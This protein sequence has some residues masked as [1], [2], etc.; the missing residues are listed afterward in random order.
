[1]VSN[2]PTAP[3]VA[4]PSK[5]RRGELKR[6][7]ARGKAAAVPAAGGASA[8]ERADK[9]IQKWRTG[10]ARLPIE[11]AVT[12]DPALDEAFRLIG[13]TAAWKILQ[14]AALES[15]AIMAE[16]RSYWNPDD[17]VEVR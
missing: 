7:Y 10:M 9:H 14:E 1:M 8:A 6:A 12:D 11:V 16:L 4:P 15:A 2:L 17:K 13:R 3:S 5:A